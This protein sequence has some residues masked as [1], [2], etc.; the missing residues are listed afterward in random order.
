MAEVC[1]LWP[2]IALNVFVESAVKLT[3]DLAAVFKTYCKGVPRGGIPVRTD[4]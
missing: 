2:Y 1:L 3:G 4:L